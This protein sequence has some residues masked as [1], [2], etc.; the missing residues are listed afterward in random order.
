[1]GS[2]EDD[3]RMR[4]PRASAVIVALSTIVAV[5]TVA[6][7]VSQ[8]TP[9]DQVGALL[10]GGPITTS[11]EPTP[12]VA[13]SADSADAPLPGAGETGAG[14]DE[15]VPAITQPHSAP[16]IEIEPA[17]AETVAPGPVIPTEPGNSATAPGQ[18]EPPGN[19]TSAPGQNRP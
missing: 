8:L 12:D 19:S 16:A 2:A 4:T 6:T 13:D 14:I 10:P 7:V 1:M 5:A 11:N 18:T 15:S 9:V 17:P 3:E